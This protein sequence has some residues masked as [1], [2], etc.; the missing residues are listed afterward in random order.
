FGEGEHARR[1]ARGEGLQRRGRERCLLGEDARDRGRAELAL[2]GAGAES[3]V[4]LDGFDVAMPLGDGVA[5][6]LEGDVLAGADEALA[7][8]ASWPTKAAAARPAAAPSRAASSGEQGPVTSP[9]AKTPGT[10]VAPW[11][12]VSTKKPPAAKRMAAPAWRARSTKPERLSAMAIK[13]TR[14]FRSSP[15]GVRRMAPA[16]R[17]RPLARTT[18]PRGPGDR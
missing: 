5:H 9:Q 15:S 1:R 18:W 3:R 16:R 10:R 17:P 8:A 11:E 12:S 6:V 2:A 4:A 14:T 13:S 7:H